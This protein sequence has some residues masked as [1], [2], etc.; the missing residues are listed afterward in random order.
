MD[1]RKNPGHPIIGISPSTF[2]PTSALPAAGS[3]GDGSRAAEATATDRCP[4]PPGVLRSV[5]SRTLA[6]RSTPTISPSE[7]QPRRWRG[8]CGKER[9]SCI[10]IY[11]YAGRP[12]PLLAPQTTPTPVYPASRLR[13]TC[14]TG[15]GGETVPRPWSREGV[16]ARACVCVCKREKK[17]TRKTETETEIERDE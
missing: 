7:G 3:I 6:R 8:V 9:V 13:D 14:A 4:S 11:V 10:Y 17:R 15:H 5:F 2:R 16:S 1:R 12:T